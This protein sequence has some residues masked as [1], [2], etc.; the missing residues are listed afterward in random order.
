MSIP[1]TPPR[2]PNTELER[3]PFELSSPLPMPPLLPSFPL[4]LLAPEPA[5]RP[6]KSVPETP[7]PEN[8]LVVVAP[9]AAPATGVGVWPCCV[10]DAPLPPDPAPVVDCEPPPVPW[11]LPVPCE[12]PFPLPDPLLVP[13]PVP[14]PL[15]LPLPLPLLSPPVVVLPPD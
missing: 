4:A 9:G 3:P 5:D 10:A 8:A 11:E 1:T 12:P 14:V 6:P 2:M 13:V 15:P 7:A